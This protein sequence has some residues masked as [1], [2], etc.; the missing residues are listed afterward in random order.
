MYNILI[1]SSYYGFIIKDFLMNIN[2]N[3][4]IEIIEWYKLT[5][6]IDYNNF[7]HINLLIIEKYNDFNFNIKYENV[8]NNFISIIPN[9]TVISY[10]LLYFNIFPF[11]F[12]HFGFSKNKIIDNLLL[13]NSKIQIIRNYEYNRLKFNPRYNYF[14]SFN[15]LIISEQ[16]TSIKPSS[17]IINNI[18]ST[19]LFI[20]SFFLP[21]FRIYYY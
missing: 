9:L 10:P 19:L 2:T 12:S 17:F 5:T 1:Y 11:Y 6:E 15:K 8:F 13:T 14:N 4:N 16:S 3:Y 20:D 7:L 18:N 21:S